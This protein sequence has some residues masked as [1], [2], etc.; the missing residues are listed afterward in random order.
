M[1]GPANQQE[2]T[3][4]QIL[5]RQTLSAL[6][7]SPVRP[8]QSGGQDRCLT[9]KAPRLQKTFGPE[10][11][12]SGLELP[13]Q[14]LQAAAV[15]QV[16]PSDVVQVT[17]RPNENPGCVRSADGRD[18]GVQVPRMGVV[19]WT[20]WNRSARSQPASSAA[21]EKKPQASSGWGRPASTSR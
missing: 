13:G 10:S 2:R 12:G 14:H 18:E 6:E 5:F 20:N 4:L 7:H 17:G 11:E 21:P 9:Q 19:S 8:S 3:D 15:E 1:S 16:V